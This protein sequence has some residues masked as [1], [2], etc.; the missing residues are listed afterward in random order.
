MAVI[1]HLTARGLTRFLTAFS[2][3]KR[4]FSLALKLKAPPLENPSSTPFPLKIPL[5]FDFHP[6]F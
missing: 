1:K 4:C 2:L 5:P 6:S 3:S